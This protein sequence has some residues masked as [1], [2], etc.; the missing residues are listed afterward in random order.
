MRYLY[1]LLIVVFAA[2]CDAPEMPLPGVTGKAGELVVVM[3]DANWKSA[4]GDTVFN[5]LS[6]HVYGLPQAEPMFNVVH[7][8]NSA[9]TKIFQTHRNI[10]HINIGAEHK[11]SIKLKTDVW[12]KPQVVVEISAPTA[13]EF[14]EV[15][16]ANASKIIS[17][18]L[19]KE[20]E[21][22]LKSYNAQLNSD[23][24][25][26]LATKFGLKL[27][28]PKG[29]NVAREE[30]DFVWVR[31]ETKDVTQS[32][33]IYTEPYTKENTFSKQGVIE[34][35]NRFSE[36]YVLGPDNGTFM[37]TYTEYPP[38]F[39]ATSIFGKYAAKLSGLWHI[40]G[41]LM[42]G[43]FVSYAFL[44]ETGKN[45]IY[46]HGFV[47]AP[48]KNKRNYLRQVGAILSGVELN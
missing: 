30:D 23:V 32:I 7:I 15:F 25:K 43:P 20:D 36:Q 24:V 41:A 46:L 21:R 45:V 14:I 40:E 27:S 42:G 26:P 39:E 4:A 13:E 9:F 35:M 3:D 2:S 34:V 16:A 22:I 18:V 48:G 29:Y 19:N 6:Q 37:S 31:Y 11:K 1:L 33:L 17:H 5:V 10:V 8:K 47:F 44:D 12:A 38:K 28:I